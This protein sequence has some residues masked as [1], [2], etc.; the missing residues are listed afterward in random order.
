MT[1]SLV[2]LAGANPSFT[3]QNVERDLGVSY[4]RASKPRQTPHC[5]RCVPGWDRVSVGI[6]SHHDL[7]SA[8]SH[9]SRERVSC[10]ISESGPA[11]RYV[12]AWGG[13]P[14]LVAGCGPRDS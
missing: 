2:D 9:V 7:F 1:A 8:R 13:G 4:H 6:I 11:V 3:A 5:R 14:P 10:S 12:G